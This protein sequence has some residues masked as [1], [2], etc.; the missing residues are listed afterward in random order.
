MTQNNLRTPQLAGF[1]RQLG[2]KNFRGCLIFAF[3]VG[4]KMHFTKFNSCSPHTKYVR[5]R[6]CTCLFIALLKYLCKTNSD[7]LPNPFGPLSSSI[8]SQ[9]IAESNKQIREVLQKDKKRGEYNKLSPEEKAVIGKYAS[10]NG[11]SKAV[12]HFQDKDSS[13]RDWKKLYEKELKERCKLAKLGEVVEVVTL[14]VKVHGR[15]T[16]LGEKLDKYLQQM[17]AD[18]HSRRTPIGSTIVVAVARG[19]L[20]KHNKAG[21]EDYNMVARLSLVRNG[22]R[23]FFEEWG[24]QSEE[25]I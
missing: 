24:S 17:I 12:R 9:T 3:F 5:P 6:Q 4:Q 10:E 23:M 7:Q 22:Q 20:L 13:V 21:L 11:V 2:C 8:P 15:P 19:I 18:M 1:A 25:R 16:L 14:P